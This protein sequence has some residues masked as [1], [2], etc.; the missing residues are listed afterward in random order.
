M[1]LDLEL[2]EC[3]SQYNSPTLLSEYKNGG[4]NHFL[5]LLQCSTVLT[6]SRWWMSLLII[7]FVSR[8]QNSEGGEHVRCQTTW[9]HSAAMW[10]NLFWFLFFCQENYFHWSNKITRSM[11]RLKECLRVHNNGT[12]N[13]K[14]KMIQKIR[15]ISKIRSLQLRV[16]TTNQT[17][18]KAYFLCNKMT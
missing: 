16:A 18:I 11:L 9:H 2:I 14:R 7:C 13:F 5:V 12:V 15:I 6:H 10:V 1:K 4:S 17:Y 8:E 3:S